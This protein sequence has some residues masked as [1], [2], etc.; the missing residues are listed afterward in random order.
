[1]SRILLFSSLCLLALACKVV[2]TTTPPEKATSYLGEWSGGNVTLHI[3]S[4]QVTYK[5]RDGLRSTLIDRRTFRGLS[6]NDVIYGENPRQLIHVDVPPHQEGTT[7]KMT[8][9][10]TAL[11]R[12]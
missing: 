4:N 9:E 6:G 8:V 1:M 12:R 7:W 10:G 2:T 3:T 11:E 5:V